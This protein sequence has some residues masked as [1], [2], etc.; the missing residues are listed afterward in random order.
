MKERGHLLFIVKQ[1]VE[2][3]VETTS[4]LARGLGVCFDK[5]GRV[6]NSSHCHSCSEQVAAQVTPR[7]AVLL[8]EMRLCQVPQD[9]CDYFLRTAAIIN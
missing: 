7:V 6:H 3:F 8:D 1:S 2:Y 4:R 9:K 5:Q